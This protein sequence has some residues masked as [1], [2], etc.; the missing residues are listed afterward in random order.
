[1]RMVCAPTR[2]LGSSAQQDYDLATIM[3]TTPEMTID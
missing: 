3:V 1:M 2:D